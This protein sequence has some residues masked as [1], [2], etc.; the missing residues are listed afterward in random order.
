MGRLEDEET[1]AKSKLEAQ[2]GAKGERVLGLAWDCETDT[3]KFSF[4]QVI[5]RARDL[6]V[7]KRNVLSLLASLFDPLGIISPVTVGMKALFQEI[8]SSKFDW[9][10]ALTGEIKEKWDK[11]IQDLTETKGIRVNRCL[12]DMGKESVTECYLHG[13]GD[14]SKKAYCAMVYFV[15][16]TTDGKTHVRLVASKTRVAPLKELTIPRLELMSARILAQLVDTIKNALQSQLKVDGVRFWLDSKT[17]LSWIQNRGEWKQ[18]VRHRVNEILRLTAKEDWSYCSTDENPADL[19]SRGVFA[20]QLKDNQLWWRGPSWLNAETNEWPVTTET[21]QT[22]ES[23]LEEEKKS[24][25]VL[26]TDIEHP[27]GVAAVIDVTHFSTLHRL[28]RVTAWVRRFVKNA[29]ARVTQ[30]KRSTGR[31]GV[32]ELKCAEVE[33]LKSVQNDLRK[34]HNFKQLV[35]ELGIKAEK[36]VLRC[37]GRLVN[38]DLESEARKPVILPRKHKF[39]RLVV[40][41][42]HQRVHHSGVRATLA[43]LR[44]RFWVPRGRQV[45]KGILGECVTCRKLTGKPY[46]APPT[47]ALP[48]FRVKEAPPFSRVGVDFAGPLYVKEKSGQMGKVYIALFSCCVTRAVRLELVEDLSAAAFRRC[49]RRFIARNGTPVLIVSDNA[50]T[51]QA[52]EKALT[53]LFDHPEV[54]ADLERDRIEW[55]FNLERA[56]WW[57]GFFERMVASVKQCLRKTLGTARLSFDELSTILTEVEGTLNSRPLTYEYN[58]LEEV[59][60]PSHL[61]YGRRVKT[62]PDE[63]AEPDDAMN[64]EGCSARF[65]YLSIKLAHFWNRWRKEYLASLREFHKNKSDRQDRI[66]QLGDV[67]VVYEE[68][69]KRGEWK[70]GIVE[71][72]VTGRDGN[73]R[74]AHVRVITKGKP[75][76][77]SRPV[78]KL[79]PLEIRSEGEET[80]TNNARSQVAEVPTRTSL[81]RNAALDSRW[82]TQLMLDS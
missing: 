77:L 71:G 76:H 64:Q 69:R 79:Y 24:A 62:L 15:Y 59:L 57:G 2:G 3:L 45:V 61:I 54:K 41:E 72:L 73:V 65:K 35:R 82:K 10:E 25:T 7:T 23:Q 18:F 16:R 29:R 63:I 51:F 37:E 48:D 17:A 38:S 19:G 60:T 39:T 22:P 5:E 33:W 4:K 6:E 74:G 58:E 9:D 52:T 80:R 53:R 31:L 36:D 70:M 46:N 1:Y 34:Q 8:C 40:E 32:E 11:W 81:R 30:V 67:V 66:V 75:V 68:D 47:A 21:Y 27:S 13:F 55:K 12:Y 43:E 20:S 42:C 50:K 44:S 78:Q 56:P 49:L 26:L 14:A 28:V